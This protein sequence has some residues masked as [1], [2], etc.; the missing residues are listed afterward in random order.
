MLLKILLDIF[1]TVI[2]QLKTKIYME[3]QIILYQ[4]FEY[5]FDINDLL[6][7]KSPLAQYNNFPKKDE[8]YKPVT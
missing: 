4:M 1:L 5:D 2:S 3:S 6:I 7:D 8:V